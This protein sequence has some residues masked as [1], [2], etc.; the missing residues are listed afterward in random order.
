[1][2][3]I[4]V[5]DLESGEMYATTLSIKEIKIAEQAKADVSDLSK[6]AERIHDRI[7]TLKASKFN[8]VNE[9]KEALRKAGFPDGA[10]DEIDE[11]FAK[12]FALVST[13]CHKTFDE[14]TRDLLT[15]KDAVVVLMQSIALFKD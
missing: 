6:E 10:I 5:V 7:E 3:K 4:F 12:A 1:M 9:V 14:Y 2:S 15:D 13:E 11:P 8:R